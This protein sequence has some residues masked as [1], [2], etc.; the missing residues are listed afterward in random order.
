M[1]DTKQKKCIAN[2]L[3]PICITLSYSEMVRVFSSTEKPFQVLEALYKTHFCKFFEFFFGV[4]KSVAICL[5]LLKVGWSVACCL[6][7]FY[8]YC[9]VELLTIVSEY[10]KQS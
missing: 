7:I 10:F 1:F 4:L 2:H 6:Y 9:S 8:V 5:R 3:F